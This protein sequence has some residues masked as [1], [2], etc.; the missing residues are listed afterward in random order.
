[1]L[2]ERNRL[3]ASFGAKPFRRDK[4]KPHIS[5]RGF[6]LQLKKQR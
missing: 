1:M 5:L 3:I 4:Q 2:N 6:D